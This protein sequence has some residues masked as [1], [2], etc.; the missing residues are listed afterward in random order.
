[1]SQLL[2]FK[3]KPFEAIHFRQNARLVSSDALVIEKQKALA[4]KAVF[5][6]AS[7]AG[8]GAGIKYRNKINHTFSAAASRLDQKTALNEVSEGQPAAVLVPKEASAPISAAMAAAENQAAYTQQR[9]QL[10]VRVASGDVAYVPAI[11]MTII[12]SWPEVDFTYTGGFHY[13]PPLDDASD[14][15]EMNLT[16]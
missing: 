1:M 4:R 15:G 11:E 9:G 12:T 8:V 13:A 2:E 6:K 7:D 16:I 10:E 5:S 14:E 3:I